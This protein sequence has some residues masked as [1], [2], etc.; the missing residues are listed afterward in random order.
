MKSL[1]LAA[2][3]KELPCNFRITHSRM[4][5]PNMIS[6]NRNSTYIFFFFERISRYILISHITEL[7]FKKQSSLADYPVN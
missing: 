3:N 2:R 5:K 6:I 1:I 4:L 7:K